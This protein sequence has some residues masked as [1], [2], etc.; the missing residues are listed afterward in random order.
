MFI[1]WANVNRLGNNGLAVLGFFD[2]LPRL[3]RQQIGHLALVPW[4]KV[5]HNQNCREVLIQPA[6]DLDERGQ[7]AGGRSDR[8]Q[9]ALHPVRWTLFFC[10]CRHSASLAAIVVFLVFKT[11]SRVM[12]DSV[13]LIS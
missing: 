10:F 7:S 12:G 1:R 9:L 3:P 6:Y 2:Q 11:S 4:V 5:L 8:Y 13:S